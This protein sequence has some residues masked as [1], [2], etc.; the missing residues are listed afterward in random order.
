M[1]GHAMDR[2]LM[3]MTA[4]RLFGATDAFSRRPFS[5]AYRPFIGPIS[6]GSSGSSSPVRQAV[7]QW[8]LCAQNR[9]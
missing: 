7:D 2:Q 9:K 3:R 8:P 4:D 6:K 1:G 5:R